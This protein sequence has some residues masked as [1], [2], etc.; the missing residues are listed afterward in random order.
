MKELDQRLQLALRNDL[1]DIRQLLHQVVETPDQRQPLVAERRVVHH[2]EH[3]GEEPVHRGPEAGRQAEGFQVVAPG[4]GRS[5]RL[6][7]RRGTPRAARS[8]PARSAGRASRPGRAFSS[9]D[10]FFTRLN[11]TASASKS[12]RR[13]DAVQR[14]EAQPRVVRVVDEAPRGT[15]RPRSPRRRRT[16]AAGTGSAGARPGTSSGRRAPPASPRQRDARLRARVER[17]ARLAAQRRQVDRRLDARQLGQVDEDLEQPVRLAA[18]PERVARAGRPLA[19]R[20][21]ARRACRA[22]RPPTRPP[23]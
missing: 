5:D 17:R 6:A 1:R 2:D 9:R 15:R 16:R 8:R 12:A 10:R 19:G 22:C 20:E 4:G 14:L 18:Q 11:A 3:V 23:T 13:P 7:P 21:R